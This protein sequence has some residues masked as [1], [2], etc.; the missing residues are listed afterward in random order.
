MNRKKALQSLKYIP[1]KD[2]GE[3]CKWKN[4]NKFRNYL[5]LRQLEKTQIGPMN[6]QSRPWSLVRDCA[7]VGS[8][9]SLLPGW[10]IKPMVKRIF[11]HTFEKCT[12][13]GFAKTWEKSILA[14]R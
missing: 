14:K 1:L 3:M 8:S 6:E 11:E 5:V 2:I 7:L 4:K 12:K 10:L 9:C 13:P